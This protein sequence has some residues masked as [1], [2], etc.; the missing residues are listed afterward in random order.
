MMA[1]LSATVILVGLP[2]VVELPMPEADV[3][4]VAAVAPI[5]ADDAASIV[6]L[7]SILLSIRAGTRS[8]TGNELLS[9]GQ[10][11][12]IPIEAGRVGDFAVLQAAAPRGQLS[13]ALSM[14]ASMVCDPMIDRDR[15][16]DFCQGPARVSRSDWDLALWPQAVWQ[17]NPSVAFVEWVQR[18]TFQRDNVT[19]AIGGAYAR[20]EVLET[21]R[22]AFGNYQPVSVDKR[23]PRH[24]GAAKMLSP[25]FATVQELE[26][27]IPTDG[28][29]T[30][31][32]LMALLGGGKGSASYQGLREQSGASYR[33]EGLVEWRKSGP[34][35]RL[36]AS[37]K[38]SL[39]EKE[40][41]T[42]LRNA[43]DSWEQTTVDEAMSVLASMSTSWMP[44]SLFRVRPG[45][46]YDHS[47]MDRTR[48]FA[49][50]MASN[51]PQ[52]SATHEQSGN[53]PIEP[54]KGQAMDWLSAAVYRSYSPKS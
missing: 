22:A 34:R 48:W 47:V 21:V 6:A 1:L 49:L 5:V 36:A 23:P 25:R 15:W 41:R 46:A 40:L 12:G 24:P 30:N 4:A 39:S 43:V 16:E 31:W 35:F 7:D 51:S 32:L 14:I 28:R 20:T 19:L 52:F 38:R 11:A 29:K 8:F 3:V 50:A 27:A 17:K 13:L 2:K 42:M 33:V 53:I 54:L 9:Y 45:V 10:Q 18:A 44:R 26:G 37:G